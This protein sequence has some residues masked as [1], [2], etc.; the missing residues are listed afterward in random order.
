M[1]YLPKKRGITDLAEA[2]SLIL[3]QF[4]ALISQGGQNY[5]E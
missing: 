4:F 3:R 1:T 5:C 2:K